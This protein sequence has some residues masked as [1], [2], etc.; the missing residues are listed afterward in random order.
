[1]E[2]REVVLLKEK[3]FELKFRNEEGPMFL[4]EGK[5]KNFYRSK[6]FRLSNEEYVVLYTNNLYHFNRNQMLIHTLS[7]DKDIGRKSSIKLRDDSILFVEKTKPRQKNDVSHKVDNAFMIYDPETKN[8]SLRV[9]NALE[10][11]KHEPLILEL[12]NENILIC[13]EKRTIRC[14]N[15]KGERLFSYVHSMGKGDPFEHI[16]SMKEI[17]ENKLLWI[18]T[19]YNYSIIDLKTLQCTVH[20][21]DTTPFVKEFGSDA[22]DGESKKYY[23]KSFDILNDNYVCIIF[24]RL[25]SDRKYSFLYNL[26]LRRVAFKTEIIHHEYDNNYDNDCIPI[27]NNLFFN[28]YRGYAFNIGERDHFYFLDGRKDSLGYKSIKE[29]IRFIIYVDEHAIILCNDENR[30]FL[31]KL[32]CRFDICIKFHNFHD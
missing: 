1:M 28:Y 4:K 6:L 26:K 15:R 30:I 32:Y 5:L 31:Y 27:K 13:D 29:K 12:E 24:H 3:G 19:I 21:I 11:N 7:Y 16:F 20:E 22:I 17:G 2:K 18:S 25:G 14:Y 9:E 8:M 10:Y 23:C